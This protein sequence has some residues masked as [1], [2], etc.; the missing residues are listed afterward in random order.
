MDIEEQYF[1]DRRKERKQERKRASAHDRS[2]YKK[3]DVAKRSLVS[4]EAERSEGSQRGRVVSVLSEGVVVARE[5]DGQRF[6]C[7]LR[8][9]LKKEKTQAKNLVGIGDYVWF[10][11]LSPNEGVIDSVEQRLTALTRA[12]NLSRRKEQL[13]AANIDQ[14]LIT[15]SVVNPPIKPPLVDRYIIATQKG[16]MIPIIVV[17]KV[18][19]L[20]THPDEE[21][22][23][24]DF[25]AAY[26][27]TGVT[28]I[29]VSAK[30]GE[31]L[32][33]LREAMRNRSSV[34]TGQSG[35]GKSSLINA[36]TGLDLRVGDTVMKTGKGAHTTTHPHLLSLVF[37][38]WCVD[39]PGIKSFGVWKL[40]KAEV[41]AYF[42]DIF[43]TGHHCRFADCSHT[44]E[45]GCAVIEAVNQGTISPMRFDSYCGLMAS[46]AEEHNRR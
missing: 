14:V 31:G 28:V 22:R 4:P 2:K 25:C 44:G 42:P 19:L 36:I 35:V 5:G 17:N 40:Y 18:D 41:E 20:S 30:T 32:D 43:E 21:Q 34:F 1:G 26:G 45:D 12:D 7:G 15:I 3:T 27:S 6:V 39:T 29:G 9:V 23:Y 11:E 37:G 10:Q 8:G 46:I 24:Q 33:A 13:I 16:G 38:G